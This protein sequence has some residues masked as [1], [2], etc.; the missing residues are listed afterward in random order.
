MSKV[1]DWDRDPRGDGDQV[2]ENRGKSKSRGGDGDGEYPT[3]VTAL[4]LI[5]LNP[6]QSGWSFVNQRRREKYG[7]LA[8]KFKY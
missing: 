8:R 1:G 2:L 4:M 7:I 6:V 3:P 5:L